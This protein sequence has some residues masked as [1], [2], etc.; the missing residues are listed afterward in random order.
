MSPYNVM[1]GTTRFYIS[2]FV[3][4]PER[5]L[6]GVAQGIDSGPSVNSRSIY[7]WWVS[8]SVELGDAAHGA[9]MHRVLIDTGL[10][11]QDNDDDDPEGGFSMFLTRGDSSLMLGPTDL[12]SLGFLTNATRKRD[13]RD[14]FTETMTS[15]ARIDLHWFDTSDPATEPIA[16]A[17]VYGAFL[18]YEVIR[19]RRSG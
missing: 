7:A 3:T 10:L 4:A 1:F 15:D 11:R 19:Q 9:K 8:P 2:D 13:V 14:V 18:E 12:A 17:D 6:S 16:K 5:D